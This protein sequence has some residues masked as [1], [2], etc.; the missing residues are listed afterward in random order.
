[1]NQRSPCLDRTTEMEH[2][3][4]DKYTLLLTYI[5]QFHR[6]GVAC[7]GGVDSTLLAYACCEA[8]GADRVVVLF[9]DSCLLSADVRSN[10]SHIVQQ[11]LPDKVTFEKIHIDGLTDK[12]FIRNDANRCYICKR[13]IYSALFS[14]LKELDII[15]LCDGTNCDD[16]GQD[17]PGLKAIEELNVLTPLVHAGYHK[18]D[19]RNTA[20]DLG[21]SNARQPSNSCLATRIEPLTAITDTRLREIESLESFLIGRGY[22]GC[23]VRPRGKMIILEVRANDLV[24]I[25]VP[26]ERQAIISYFQQNGYNS[27]VI[28]LSGRSD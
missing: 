11:Q 28:D 16:L 19:V 17:R 15:H 10:I 3:L 4:Q 7:S 25:T 14:R 2:E 26:A 8:L 20:A 23:R 6:V 22:T 1:M 9:A 27:V 21:L 18:A 24:R 13:K 5:R 12:E